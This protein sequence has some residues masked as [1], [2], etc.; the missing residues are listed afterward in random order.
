M[1]VIGRYPVIQ[2]IF[3]SEIR[4]NFGSKPAIKV[5]KYLRLE[6]HRYFAHSNSATGLGSGHPTAQ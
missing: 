5:K 2:R 1:E 3:G 6:S 4:R